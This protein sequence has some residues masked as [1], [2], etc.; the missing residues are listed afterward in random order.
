MLLTGSS[1]LGLI[2]L[3]SASLHY[4][5]LNRPL[6]DPYPLKS[7]YRDRVHLWSMMRS[8]SHS[9]AGHG[10]SAAVDDIDAEPSQPLLTDSNNSTDPLF[11]FQEI[12]VSMSKEQPGPWNGWNAEMS[13]EVV[14]ELRAADRGQYGSSKLER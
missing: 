8:R 6:A 2:G 11:R 14:V 13:L 7:L 4:S 12:L 10:N 5:G 1:L 9:D 3:D